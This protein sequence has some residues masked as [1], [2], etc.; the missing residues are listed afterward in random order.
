VPATTRIPSF[1]RGN[2]DKFMGDGLMAV[3]GAPVTHSND[4]ERAVRC[5]LK[6]QESITAHNLKREAAGLIPL[7]IGIGI[8][9]GIAVAGNIGSSKR[10][11]Y[12]V[13]G[14]TVNLAARVQGVAAPGEVLITQTTYEELKDLLEAEILPPQYLK[15]KADEV[16]VYRINSI[17]AA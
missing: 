14:D 3:F 1:P 7:R 17:R 4:A 13:I 16:V 10:R 2:I 5:A 9:T 11:E 15:G 12:S 6:M 8:H